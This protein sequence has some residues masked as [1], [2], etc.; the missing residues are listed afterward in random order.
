MLSR[1]LGL[2]LQ[3]RYCVHFSYF[4]SLGFLWTLLVLR[5]FGYDAGTTLYRLSDMA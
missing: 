2:F 5:Y 4:F 1:I 3:E